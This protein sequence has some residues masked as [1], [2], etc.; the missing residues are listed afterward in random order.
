MKITPVI[1]PPIKIEPPANPSFGYNPPLKKA[2]K[3]GL[4]PEVTHGLF[5]M[6][7]DNETVTTEHLTPAS[8]GGGLQLNNIA[9]SHWFK[10][11]QRG[12]E[13]IEKFVT[14][15]MWIKYLK[16]F[17]NV[18]NKYVDGMQYIKA[19]CKRFKF[20]IKEVLK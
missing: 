9:L 11:C 16:Q 5:G 18:K 15:E 17:I 1:F 19:I 8:K 10:N 7:I 4:M 6:P 3:K 14:K 13:P 2:F 12:V 20:D